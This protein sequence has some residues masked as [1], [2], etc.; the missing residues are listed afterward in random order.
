[1]CSGREVERTTINKNK[2]RR[3]LAWIKKAKR[4]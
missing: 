2:E 4:K 3:D 1:V